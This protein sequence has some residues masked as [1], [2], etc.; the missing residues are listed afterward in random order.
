MAIAEYKPISISLKKI[1]FNDTII[2]S[3]II[4]VCPILIVGLYSFAIK[5]IKSVPPVEELNFNKIA[6]PKPYNYSPIYTC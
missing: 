5:L 6:V 3:I 4:I 1:T 2:T